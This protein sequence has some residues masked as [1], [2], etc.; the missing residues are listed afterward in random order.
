MLEVLGRAAVLVAIIGIGLGAK[1]VGWVAA[2]DFNL[3]S[4]ILLRIT[5]PC[6]LATSFNTFTVTPGLVYV[7][8]L[9]AAVSLAQEAIGFVLGGPRGRRGRA[10][11][12]LNVGTFNIGLFAVPY[13]AV[14]LGPP[15]LIYAA[16]FDVGQTLVALGIGLPW[17]TALTGAGESSPRAIAR[18]I[19]SSVLFDVYL[20]L[21]VIALLGIKLPA[22]VIA[23]TSTVGSANTFLA[24][25]MIGVGLELAQGRSRLAEAARHLAARYAWSLVVAVLIWFALPVER[26]VRLVLTMVVFAPVAAMVPG[27]TAESKGDVALSTFI[28]SI[29]VLVGIVAMP[30]VLALLGA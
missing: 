29:S 30:G 1:R 13:L 11:G 2:S 4:R 6:A 7:V 9:G 26:E 24:M 20:F 21:L 16:L 19:F 12:V 14:L 27:L 8:A 10:F 22:P 18:R 25:F 15:A 28:T 23:L 17:A 5:L 3:L